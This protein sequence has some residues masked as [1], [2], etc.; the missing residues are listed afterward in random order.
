MPVSSHIIWTKERPVD[1]RHQAH[2]LPVRTQYKTFHLAAFAT[3]MCELLAPRASLRCEYVSSVQ[4]HMRATRNA[5]V[6]AGR[7]RSADEMS[8]GCRAVRRP[9]RQIRRVNR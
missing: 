5:Q 6:V 9:S 1:I 2:K 4:W 3:A 8:S 7:Q